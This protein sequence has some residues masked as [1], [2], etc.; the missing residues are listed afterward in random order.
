VEIKPVTW[1][2]EQVLSGRLAYDEAPAAI[3]SWL[4]H[5][6][7]LG[8]KEICL[9]ENVDE[10]RAFITKIPTLIRPYIEAEVKRFWPVRREL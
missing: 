3:Q 10:R 5:D 6:I 8:A 2:R 4:R 1:W 9:M 7:Y